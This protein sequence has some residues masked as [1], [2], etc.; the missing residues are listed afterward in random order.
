LYAVWQDYRNG[1]F[2]VQLSQ[3]LDGGLTWHE[4][5]TVNPDRGLDHYFPATDQTPQGNDRNGVSYFRTERV[6][7][8]NAGA[9]GG[10]KSCNP[11]QGGNPSA[12]NAGTGLGNSD[13]V[14][15]GGRGDDTPY[16]FKVV[17]PVFPPPDGGQSGFNGDYSGL[18]I[19]RGEEAHPIWSDTRNVVPA[20]INAQPPGQG[21]AH[22]EDIFTDTVGLPNGRGSDRESGRIGED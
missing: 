22:D 13:Y 9:T 15:A 7:N 4:A 19:N 18:T 3:S 8:E 5:G 17:S 21:V 10:F 16:A 11:A 2:D 14:L 20:A 12:C 1:E 6:P